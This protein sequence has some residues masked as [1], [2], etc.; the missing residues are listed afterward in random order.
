[1]TLEELRASCVIPDAGYQFFGTKLE[2]RRHKI[3]RV[4]HFLQSD[5]ILGIENPFS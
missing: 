5:M 1:M 4:F 3:L 2:A